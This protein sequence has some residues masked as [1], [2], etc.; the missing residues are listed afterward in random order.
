MET[1]IICIGSV[2]WDVIGRTQTHSG[3]GGDVA[4]LIKEQAGGVAFNIAKLFSRK[5]CDAAAEEVF[6]ACVVGDSTH[7]HVYMM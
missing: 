1:P 5:G 6:A 3:L 4:G 2:L 7:M